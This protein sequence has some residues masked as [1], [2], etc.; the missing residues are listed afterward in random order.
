[1]DLTS[2][3]LHDMVCDVDTEIQDLKAK[4]KELNAQVLEKQ[5][6]CADCE[7]EII[8]LQQKKLSCLVGRTFKDKKRDDYFIVSHVPRYTRT[9]IGTYNFNPY[10]IPVTF[11]GNSATHKGEIYMGKETVFSNAVDCDDVLTAFISD[12]YE[13]ISVDDFYLAACK[14]ITERIDNIRRK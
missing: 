9:R 1:M 11:V 3:T 10:Q 7:E 2:E 4:R 5:A 14:L 12:K 13:E 8:K 6:E